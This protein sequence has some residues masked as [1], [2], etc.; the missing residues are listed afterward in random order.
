MIKLQAP[1]G[2]MSNASMWV[3]S[4]KL[5]LLQDETSAVS[6]SLSVRK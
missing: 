1:R 2:T 4:T 3:L 6:I 5:T